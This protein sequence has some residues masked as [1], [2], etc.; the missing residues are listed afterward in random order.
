MRILISVILAA[1]LMFLV[2]Q[3]V[4]F[5]DRGDEAARE[6]ANIRTELE[7]VKRDSEAIRSDRDFFTNPLNLEKE[8]RARF[9]YRSEE[10]NL[11]ILVP[12]PSSTKPQ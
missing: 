11:L 5:R 8:L 7:K 12:S 6:L 10:E 1:F 3:A 2:V 9:N 4:I